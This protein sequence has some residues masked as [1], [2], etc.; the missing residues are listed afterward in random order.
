MKFLAVPILSAVLYLLSVSSQAAETAPA[1]DF[2]LTVDVFGQVWMISCE[3]GEIVVASR[4]ADDW[5]E[6]MRMQASGSPDSP[7]LTATQEGFVAAWLERTDSAS[8]LAVAAINDGDARVVRLGTPSDSTTCFDMAALSPDRIG[9]LLVRQTAVGNSL[10][11]YELEADNLS[12]VSTKSISSTGDLSYPSVLP[13][14]DVWVAW[15]ERSN[16]K[17]AVAASNISANQAGIVIRRIVDGFGGVAA[18][19]LIRN[20]GLQALLIWQGR[21]SAGNAVLEAGNLSEDGIKSVQTIAAPDGIRGLLCPRAIPGD[22]A[23]I[24]TYGWGGERWSAVRIRFGTN[25]KMECDIRA[26][27]RSHM[28]RPQLAIDGRGNEIWA[29]P[30]DGV[31][32]GRVISRRGD[33]L[34]HESQKVIQAPEDAIPAGR[35]RIL[36]FGDSIT[37]GKM[38]SPDKSQVEITSGYIDFLEEEYS[39]RIR[40]VLVIQS[41]I[42]G[43]TTIEGLVRLQ[44][45]LQQ[46]PDIEFVLILEGTN[47]IF[48][49]G[50]L[51]ETVAENLGQMADMV[52]QAGSIPV[53]S[54]L[55]PRFDS[56]VIRRIRAESISKAILPTARLRGATICDFQALFPKDPNLFSDL[57]LHPNLEGYELMADYWIL[58]LVTFEGDVDRS[59]V[60]DK[61]DLLLLSAVLQTRRGSWAF[62]PDADFN[63]DGHVDTRDLSFLLNRMKKSFNK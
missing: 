60:V 33:E 49:P 50:F 12:I 29:W 28:R 4:E 25:G 41:G 17:L 27:S 53:L 24:T 36:A 35:V 2:S 47:D 52:R 13:D 18:P 26:D 62:N 30:E 43:E 10:A 7:R 31:L 32:G 57:R 58:A 22:P 38:V 56:D 42:G 3:G 23:G 59:F 1:D 19:V 55:L 16:G 45:V 5:L 9:I 15:Q 14:P 61:G 11:W 46:Y 54:T 39:Q 6:R 40:P 8:G 63:D 44:A 21:D 20:G 34:Q 48:N 51:P 37:E